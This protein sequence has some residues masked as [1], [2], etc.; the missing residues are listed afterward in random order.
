[1]YRGGFIINEF[2]SPLEIR[3]SMRSATI[4]VLVSAYRNT[5]YAPFQRLGAHALPLDVPSQRY[6]SFGRDIDICIGLGHVR[7]VTHSSPPGSDSEKYLHRVQ[8][9]DDTGMPQRAQLLQGV[10]RKGHLVL[11]GGDVEGEDATV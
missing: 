3:Q 5:V 6:Q 2:Q 10:L 11:I 4:A 1:M 9:L 7:S 8:D